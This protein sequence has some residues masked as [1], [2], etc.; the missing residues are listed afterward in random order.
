[1]AIMLWTYFAMIAVLFGAA[2][3]RAVNEAPAETPSSS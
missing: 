3:A 1:M 2:F